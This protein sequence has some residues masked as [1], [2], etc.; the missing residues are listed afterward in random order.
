MLQII[1]KNP[2]VCDQFVIVIAFHGPPFYANAK[3]GECL[4]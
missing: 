3:T 2:V 1:A 4:Q